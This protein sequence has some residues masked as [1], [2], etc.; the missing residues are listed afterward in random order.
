MYFV[1]IV[2]N[3]SSE[4]KNFMKRAISLGEKGRYTASPNPWV[5][6][7]VVQDGRV[8]GEGYHV[9]PGTPHAEVMAL[10]EAKELARG[11]DLYV[12]L[13]P[14]CHTGRTPPCT[15]AIHKAGIGRLF[16]ALYDPDPKVGGRGI[17]LLQK[18]GIVVV[19]GVASEEAEES[20]A[21]Y[22]F[23]RREKRPFCWLKAAISMDGKMAAE[24]GSSQWISC[25]VA[26]RDGHTLR[27]SSQAIV[28]GGGTALRDRPQ[29]TV[30]DIPLPEGFS[31]PLRVVLD[32][33]GVVP[34]E[35]PLFDP[36][37]GQTLFF[38]TNACSAERSKEWER[39]GCDVIKVSPTEKGVDLQEVLAHLYKRGVLQVLVEGGPTLLGSFVQERRAQRLSTYVGSCLIGGNGI[40]F[41]P[42]LLG[43]SIDHSL[44]FQME[45]SVRLGETTRMDYQLA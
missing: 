42:T 20:L 27:A 1:S 12:T 9:R 8:V 19:E 31:P 44:R 35:G 11:A 30:R 10:R 21:P 15:E 5:G 45:R 4:P 33:K 2:M 13:E 38:T 26:R 39:R 25:E 22:L 41:F 28:V 36:S 37:L 29:L 6:A 7:V 14:C 16:V 17:E 23:H 24:D 32:G 43:N 18:E 3:P 40:P 34:P